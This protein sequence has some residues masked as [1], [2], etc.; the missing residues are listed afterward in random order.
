MDNDT[1]SWLYSANA[2]FIEDLYESYLTDPGSIDAG[3]RQYFDDLQNSGKAG[4]RDVPH[5]PIRKAFLKISHQARPER[6]STSDDQTVDHQKQVSVLQLINAHRFLGHRQ[7]DLDPLKQY[8]RPD[9]PELDPAYHGLTESDLDKTFNIG[10]LQHHQSEIP[11]HEIIR[12]IKTT[13]CRTIG[14]EYMHINETEQKRWIQQRLESCC[15]TPSYSREKRIRILERTIA[16]NAL[17]EY[18]HTKYVG[19]KRFSLEGGETVIPLLDEIIQ[20]SGEQ[21]VREIVIGMAHRGRINVLVNTIGK[22]PRDLFSEFEGKGHTDGN[23]SGDVKYHLGYSSDIE[24]QNGP[25]H[26][27]LS[28]NPSHLEIIDP[29]VEGSVRARQERRKD[30]ERNQVLPILLH[31]DAAFAGQG[32]VME[33][34]NLSQTRGYTTGGTVHIIINNQ[35]G[36]TTSDP[37]DSRSTLY[38]TDVA[39]VVQAPIFH[40]NADDPEAVVFIAK[41][42]LDYRMEFNKDI[43]IDMI[44]YRKHGHSEAD[45][46]AATQP[47]M[48]KQ[49]RKHPGVR[50]LF[51]EKLIK[52]DVITQQD[53]DKLHDDYI[54][55]LETN[56]AVA[57]PQA[58]NVSRDFLIDFSPYKGTHWDMVINSNIDSETLKRLV[59]RITYIPEEFKLHPTVQRIIESRIKMGKGELPMDW[60]FAETMAY[61]SLVDAGYPVRLSGQ[62]SGRGTFFHRHAVIHDQETG[63]TYLPLQHISENQSKFLV[64]NSTLSEEAVLAYEY[65]FSSAEPGALVIWEAQFGD[66]ANG[67]QVVIDQFI[68]SSE[69]KWGRYCGLVVFLP[70][71]YDGQGPEHSSARLE[72][73]LQL[74][75]QENMQVCVPSSAGQMFHML[76]R[77]IM[78]PYRKPLIVMSPKSLLRHK[79]STTPINDILTG[80]FQTVIDEIDDLDKSQVTRLLFCSGKV[81]YDLLEARRENEIKNIAIARIEQLFPF[82]SDAVKR[83]LSMY[84]NLKEVVWVQEEPKNQGSWYSMQ[85]RGTM[86]GCLGEQH[87]FGYAGRFYSAS[88]A[89]GYMSKH[90]EQQKQLVA[91]ALQLDKLEVTHNKNTIR[92]IQN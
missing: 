40:V 24:T 50:K 84:E 87:T 31:G 27:T 51:T 8:E 16:A 72:R 44:C 33:T 41:L 65:G 39:K 4:S 92:A 35:I 80:R 62:D 15:A 3:W 12:I 37:L 91:D 19:Q 36:F 43:V 13:Y 55:S 76:R 14:A 81:Y 34:F 88:P 17:E 66:F 85:S 60:G 49:I 5:S 86:I 61:A 89:V 45:E 52:E 67:A 21:Q 2:S 82:P 10:S 26:L 11:L 90:L 64:I 68:S 28:F 59:E 18:L 42:A 23:S 79:L 77:Q 70:H 73:Y 46:P 83:V 53:A 47:I 29:V 9:V 63:N 58:T 7:A 75:A 57:G 74:C 56:R 48:Y 1:S 20:D 25:V 71:G 69:A 78:R 22:L 54:D 30:I 38:C 32:V 6:I